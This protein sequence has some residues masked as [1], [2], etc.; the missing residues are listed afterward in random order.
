[1]KNEEIIAQLLPPES[2][3]VNRTGLK[4][5]KSHSQKAEEHSRE[6]MKNFPS[7]LP[8]EPAPWEWPYRLP[9]PGTGSRRV[10]ALHTIPAL[11]TARSGWDGILM[12]RPSGERRKKNCRNTGTTSTAIRLSCRDQKIWFRCSKKTG[13]PESG[14]LKQEKLLNTGSSNTG[15]ASKGCGPAL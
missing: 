3:Q 14:N 6:S 2:E 15:R 10:S 11:A 1:K 7:I 4:F 9:L 12:S 8:M 13:L 5:L